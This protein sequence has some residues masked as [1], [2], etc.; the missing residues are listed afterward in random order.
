MKI[1]LIKTCDR[2]H[3][4]S[5][6]QSS[7]S[8]SQLIRAFAIFFVAASILHQ[9]MVPN[10]T[11]YMFDYTN[12]WYNVLP[13]AGSNSS[14]STLTGKDFESLQDEKAALMQRLLEI[15]HSLESHINSNRSNPTPTSANLAAGSDGDSTTKSDDA[16]GEVQQQR[17]IE[18]N[19]S[20]SSDKPQSPSLP[21]KLVH[22]TQRLELGTLAQRR[23]QNYTSP[24]CTIQADDDHVFNRIV[25]LHMR[26]AGGSSLRNF[27]K[28]VAQK[29]KIPIYCM[30]GYKVPEK[31]GDE[32]KTLYVTHLR[33]P[34]SRVISHFKYERRWK[35]DQLRQL[36]TD[37]LVPMENHTLMGLKEFTE[38]R[39]YPRNKLW[40]CSKECYARWSTGWYHHSRIYEEDM[41]A[42]A[43]KV[44]GGYHLIVISEWLKDPEYARS[45]EALFGM[46]GID[47]KKSPTCGEATAW[48]NKMVPYNV[49]QEEYDIMAEKN[50][51]DIR[52]YNE[53]ATCRYG[54]KFGNRTIRFEEFVPDPERNVSMNLVQIG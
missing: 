1:R 44:L 45:L 46:G 35:C 11:K 38:K 13:E 40:T 53:L 42:K 5:E 22:S 2:R 16:P 8:T 18:G 32:N 9:L 3:H 26:K 48:A 36:R 28:E 14:T 51:V 25:F 6:R 52:L 4:A 17:S 49:T 10:I 43:G 47:R 33:E 30:E 21:A 24:A 54:P 41:E 29:K 23:E 20:R 7:A 12:S 37:G 34:I 15:D 50:Y 27:L 31:P 39:W 19:S